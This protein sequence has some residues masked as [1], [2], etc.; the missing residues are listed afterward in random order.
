MV[1]ELNDNSVREF[2]V[3]AIRQVKLRVTEVD[4]DYTVAEA[5]DLGLPSGTKW[6]SWNIG[7][8]TATAAMAIRCVQSASSLRIEA[9]K[10]A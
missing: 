2:K 9:F 6:A 5:I 1:I 8:F 7:A 4:A 3:D 10:S